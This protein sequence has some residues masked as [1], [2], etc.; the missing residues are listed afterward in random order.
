MPVHAGDERGCAI[1]KILAVLKIEDG[2]VA[3]GLII[4]AG[5][6]IDDEVALVSEKARTETFVLAEIVTSR[7]L[8]STCCPG[9]T[10]S[11]VTRP[12]MGA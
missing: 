3:A 6:E 8:A 2:K 11:F 5:R 9:A 4:V 7:S 1:K 12:L 10:R